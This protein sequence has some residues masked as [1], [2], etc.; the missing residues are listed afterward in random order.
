MQRMHKLCMDLRLVANIQKNNPLA[1]THVRIYIPTK[2]GRESVIDKLQVS[3]RN[4]R[5]DTAQSTK[6]G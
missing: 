3:L 5:S 6:I 2:S 4:I 1:S